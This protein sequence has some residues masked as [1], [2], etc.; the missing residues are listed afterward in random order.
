MNLVGSGQ[1]F[2]GRSDDGPMRIL[3]PIQRVFKALH[4]D[5][6]QVDHVGAQGPFVG[7]NQGLHHVAVVQKPFRLGQDYLAQVRFDHFGSN[8]F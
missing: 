1:V 5:G 4:G 7:G 3:Q 2:I 6:P 8:Q